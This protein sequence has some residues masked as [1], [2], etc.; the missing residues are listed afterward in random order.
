MNMIV[1]FEHFLH[2]EK[3]SC[4]PK[5]LTV[6][7]FPSHFFN[8]NVP[9]APINSRRLFCRGLLFVASPPI[10]MSGLGSPLHNH[11]QSKMAP[12]ISIIAL[13]NT[14]V[15]EISFAASK[16]FSWNRAIWNLLIFELNWL[17]VSCLKFRA[18][19]LTTRLNACVRGTFYPCSITFLACSH[20][21]V[22]SP[23][24]AQ[25]HLEELINISSPLL[26]SP[27]HNILLSGVTHL[28]M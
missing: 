1:I 6:S 9:P 18:I 21:D 16:Y 14:V 28:E 11:R 13:P 26:F 17:F 22:T 8:I 15:P 10:V 25:T 3:L 5:T 24:R 19:F 7:S 12:D 23:D 20:V 2:C 27:P 4:L